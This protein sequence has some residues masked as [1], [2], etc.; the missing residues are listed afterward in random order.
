MLKGAVAERYAGAL[1]GIAQE[2]GLMEKIE[3]ELRGILEALDA[4]P[5]FKR[6][7]YHPQVPAAV[8]KEIVKEA[9]GGQ[10]ETYTLNF[11]NVLLDARREVFFKD[12]VQEY[13]RLV[14]ETRNV[15]EVTVTSA[16]E[17][18][19][20]YK[21]EL[22]AALAKATGKEVRVAYEKKTEIL[23]GLVIRIGNRVIDSSVARQLERLREQI[24][25]I[26]VG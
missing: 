4:S 7:F 10:V 5:D 1:F 8:K 2:K 16:V 12:I 6:V 13:T 24:R 3:E 11:I 21:D 9:V 19:A 18:P 14:N 15:V 17:V 23:G 20:A 26:R 25:Q 22:V